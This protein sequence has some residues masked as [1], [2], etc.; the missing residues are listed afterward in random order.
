MSS[1]DL[2]EVLNDDILSDILSN[3]NIYDMKGIKSNSKMQDIILDNISRNRFVP[4]IRETLILT[5]NE[6][7]PFFK[8]I[9]NLRGSHVYIDDDVDDSI[10]SVDV[11]DSVDSIGDNVGDININKYRVTLAVAMY[12]R[13]PVMII[14][15]QSSHI[16]RKNI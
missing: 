14:T 9:G 2:T 5:V 6:A 8:I 15:D 4:L 1:L 11:D 12:F 13:L 3:L 10:D 7:E 16:W